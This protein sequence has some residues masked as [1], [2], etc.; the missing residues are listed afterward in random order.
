MK[1]KLSQAII[2]ICHLFGRGFIAGT[3]L[4]LGVLGTTLVAQTVTSWTDG[5]TLNATDLNNVVNDINTLFAADTT[6][7]TN[8]AAVNTTATTNSTNIGTLN[9][10]VTGLNTTVTG[11]NTTV[12]GHTTSIGTLN[13]Y[14]PWTV[15][16]AH[17]Y[18]PSGNV[19]IGPAIPAEKLE[20]SG[21]LLIPYLNWLKMRDSGS[22][23]RN[24]I[25]TTDAATVAL[26]PIDNGAPSRVQIQTFSGGNVA[27]FQNNGFVGIGVSPAQT[28]L[29]IEQSNGNGGLPEA[30]IRIRNTNTF[31]STLIGFNA[32]RAWG[33]GV[34]GTGGGG[35]NES[36][37]IY[38]WDSG[39][40][41]FRIDTLG[42]IYHNGSAIHS[43]GRAKE[44]IRPIDSALQKIAMLDGVTF[45]WKPEYQLS[46][47]R[48]MGV[49]AQ[50]VER[51]FPEAVTSSGGQKFVNYSA[52]IAPLI[53]AV[54]ELEEQNRFLLQEIKTLKRK[55]GQNGEW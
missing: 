43:D 33:I 53:E 15:S 4:A 24:V 51:S 31:N 42:T 41:R 50:D 26:R 35:L 18:R 13:G 16:G 6:I 55:S 49:I 29:H 23:V 47:Q 19:G 52:L 37:Q 27:T 48:Q 14:A 1:K 8:I 38:D 45:D 39:V 10:T 28:A 32:N 7:N 17:A 3:G 11:L 40:E 5:Q 22:N 25:G 2:Q 44:S 21:S 46:R 12:T 20:V 9:T 30:I 54:K 36:F 34:W